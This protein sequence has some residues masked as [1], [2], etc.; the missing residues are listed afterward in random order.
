MIEDKSIAK[1]TLYFNFYV[2]QAL[3][4]AGFGSEIL[5]QLKQWQEF[6]DYGFTTF[7]EHGVN[8]RSDCHAWSS[9]PMV[10]LLEI[11]CGITP[12][13]PGFKHVLIEPQL[14]ELTT[15]EGS[16]IHPS[17]KIITRYQKEQNGTLK[18]EIELPGDL[19]GTFVWNEKSYPLKGGVNNYLCE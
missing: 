2:F 18:C 4:K 14:G 10:G 11:T 17:G 13:T 9:H 16:V 8:S 3:K 7:P 15:I 19:T 5:P 12:A 1:A 6:I